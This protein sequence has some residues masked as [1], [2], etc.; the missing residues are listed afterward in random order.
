MKRERSLGYEPRD[1]ASENRGCDIESRDPETGGLRLTEIK[2]RCADAE[3]VTVTRNKM[4]TA[5]NAGGSFILAAVLVEDGFVHRL[6]YVPD[7]ARIFGPPPGFAE[8]SRT[9][10]VSA[11]GKAA[12]AGP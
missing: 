3:A 10:S 1:A 7:P 8:V 6:L 9:I 11:I 12:E 5:L 2:G 4:L